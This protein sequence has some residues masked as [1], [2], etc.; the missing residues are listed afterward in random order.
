LLV[1][2]KVRRHSHEVRLYIIVS[3]CII[4]AAPRPTVQ[5]Q[6]VKA[7]TGAIAIG[8]N[9]TSSTINIGVS[10]EQLAAL[11]RQA[12][13]LSD[14]QKKLIARLE[15]ELDLNQRQ[16]HAAL[17]ILGEADVP[18]D[19]LPAK[20]IEFAERFKDLQ[21][22]ALSQSDDSS[23]IAVRKAD[24]QK[25]IDAGELA[26]ADA[27]LADVETEQKRALDRHAIEAA[28]TSA[29]R[30]RIASARLRY[31]E[32]AN[33]FANAA[34]L[35]PQGSGSED[36]QFEYLFEE[37]FALYHQ[38]DEF[39]DNAALVS[40]IERLR[41]LAELAMRPLPPL[42]EKWAIVENNLAIAITTLG[43]RQG[44]MA[45]LEEAV[46]IHRAVLKES[47]RER[48][49]LAW[50]SIEHSLGAAL[51]EIGM[52]E[53]DTASLK[54]AVAAYREA[55]K[56]RT[57]ER[58]P[59]DWAMTEADLGIALHTLALREN[60]A[61]KLDEAIATLREAQ[62]ECT[63]ER[64]PLAWASTEHTLGLAFAA[65]AER[66]GDTSK[67]EEAVRAYREALKEQTRKRLP[68]EWAD[69]EVNLGVALYRLGVLG[70]DITKLEE[71]AASDREAL[72][73]ITRERTPRDWATAEFNLGEALTAI[74][75]RKSDS[76]MLGEA[77]TAYSE[78]LKER[79]REQTPHDW[80]VTEGDLGI[81]RFY[82]GNFAAAALDLQ[83][84]AATD[85]TDPYLIIWGYLARA[86][87][88]APDARGD[89]EQAAKGFHPAQW[90]FPVIKLLLEQGTADA[91]V[92][93]ADG[94]GER[95]EAQYYL[96][97]WH[98]LR[99]TRANSIEAL[100]NAIKICQPNFIEYT[101]A[102]AELN[103]LEK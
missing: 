36:K 26:R 50:A 24:V 70:R 48:T 84:A 14:A 75:V 49:P 47:S 85:K 63:R 95:C 67:L 17:D 96:G 56:E 34:A 23:D 8:G 27:L 89:L 15:S 62:K 5:A 54:E 88:S 38:G 40:A 33:H 1:E 43:R 80:A 19:R 81:V 20:L 6:Q 10:A 66:E 86:R 72:K 92:A 35:L 101:G 45:K 13:D 68:L 83:E 25:A 94:P 30:G 100:Q 18:P 16:I 41:K 32:A 46:R 69:T 22:T 11:V 39:G 98:L 87:A 78:A 60:D 57:R 102:Q 52:Q 42:P 44:D 61:A 90:P 21:A 73:E 29:R 12:N 37:A 79:S 51:T 53:S 77:V 28:D 9:V 103:R 7:D 71:A 91:M 76:A 74:G 93:A 2:T 3:L 58:V 31:L 59:L 64:A 65:V 99:G 97:E 55:L 82:Q 4:F